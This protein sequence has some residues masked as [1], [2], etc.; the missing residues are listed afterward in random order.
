MSKMTTH[1]RGSKLAKHQKMASINAQMRLLVPKKISEDDHLVEY[2]TIL[3]D[4]FLDILQDL[5]GPD[6]KEIVCGTKCPVMFF[7]FVN[8][9]YK[10]IF[11]YYT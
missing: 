4:R 6:V 7:I 3:L 8:I 11:Q 10:Y 5:H 1:Q 9:Y 2:D